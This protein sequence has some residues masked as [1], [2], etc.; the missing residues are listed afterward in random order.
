M[1]VMIRKPY[2]DEDSFGPLDED[3]GEEQD[4]WFLPPTPELDPVEIPLPRAAPKVLLPASEWRAAEGA[5]AGDLAQLCYDFGRLEERLRH[6]ESGARRRLALQEVS[7]LGWWTGDR[8]PADRL[9]LWLALQIGAT[10]TDSQALARSAWAVRRLTSGPAP[11]DAEAMAQLLGVSEAAGIPERVQD[12]MAAMAPLASLHPVV[13][14]CALFHLWR[15]GDPGPARDLEAAVLAARLAGMVAGGAGAA[16]LP[17]SM[18]GFSGLQIRG[19]VEAR[20]TGWVSGA[21]QSVL[22]SLLHLDR[23]AAWEA[24][25]LEAISDLSGRTP[26]RLLRLLA[27]WPSVSAPMAEGE[28]GS[29]RAAVQRNLDLFANRGLV[30]ELT[31]QGRYRVWTA[32]LG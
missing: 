17:L 2:D 20:L 12:V 31:G 15:L 7:G 11:A 22:A 29:S 21:H 13:Q 27:D 16:W 25:A 26:P 14:G 23:L 8:V 1:R 24:R 3:E 28:T 6:R 9:V 32:H 10:G 5:L 30:R 19:S 4:L 18:A